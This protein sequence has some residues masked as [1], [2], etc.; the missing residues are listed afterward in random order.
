MKIKFLGGCNEVGRSAILIDDK[1][2][3]DYGLRPSEP[4][5]VPVEGAFPKSACTP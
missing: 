1:I 2:V 3:M 5:E 4:P